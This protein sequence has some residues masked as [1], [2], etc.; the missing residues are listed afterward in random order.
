MT[1]FQEYLYEDYIKEN[2][3]PNINESEE[4][5]KSIKKKVVE[6]I[7]SLNSNIFDNISILKNIK[8]YLNKKEYYNKIKD[9]DSNVDEKKDVIKIWVQK[10]LGNDTKQDHV[11]DF[12][13]AILDAANQTSFESILIL[14]NSQ[15]KENGFIKLDENSFNDLSLEKIKE[16]YK[17]TNYKNEIN[18]SKEDEDWIIED[19]FWD[20]L[21]LKMSGTQPVI[22]KGEFV[23]KTIGK[24]DIN[25]SGVSDINISGK[26]CEIKYCA[27]NEAYVGNDKYG[28]IYPIYNLWINNDKDKFKEAQSIGINTIGDEYYNKVALPK[29]NELIINAKDGKINLSKYIEDKIKKGDYNYSRKK[30]GQLKD[31]TGVDKICDEFVKKL[32][33]VKLDK[34]T[35]VR[36]VTVFYMMLYAKYEGFD[37]LIFIMP[38]NVFKCIQ[39]DSFDNIYKQDLPLYKLRYDADK[40]NVGKYGL[41][42]EKNNQVEVKK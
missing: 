28:S 4:D 29:L 18:Y 26:K 17:S 15:L 25:E 20:I 12:Y 27:I 24:V 5:N 35:F 9:K 16:Y 39:I 10:K 41:Y 40:L 42:D 36:L 7:N 13:D 2:I 14:I 33:E 21:L 31:I 11:N 1:T 8:S 22:G 6:Y 3:I 30:G 37:N 32:L 23:L 19:K 38:N 34:L